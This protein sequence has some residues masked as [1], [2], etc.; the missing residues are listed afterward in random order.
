VTPAGYHHATRGAQLLVARQELW[1]ALT[2]LGLLAT[3]GLAPVLRHAVPGARGRADTWILS[4][5]GRPER[6]L[7]RRMRHGG[8]VGRWLG[9][10]FLGPQRALN[11]LQVTTQLHT[12]GAPVPKPALVW[13]HRVVGPVWLG[14]I[15]T[16]YEEGARDA[17]A[18]L[19]GN[20]EVAQLRA[21][22]RALGRAVRRFHDA[23]GCH[24]D[25]HAGNLLLVEATGGLR[26]VVVDLDRARCAVLTPEQRMR[27][28]MRLYRSLRKQGVL[29]QVGAAGCAAFFGAYCG[30][31]RVLRRALH[32]RL[33]WELRRV[34]LHALH[35]RSG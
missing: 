7:L 19:R 31:D 2:Q 33:G 20:P 32:A 24:A 12:A 27:Q 15:A 30:G 3:D 16:V 6:L 4:L 25:L 8:V 9:G 26:G 18:F 21:A 10:H 1:P 29:A 22:A 11:E 13:G 23:G 28:L 34:A 17:L 5:P 35:Y 14:C